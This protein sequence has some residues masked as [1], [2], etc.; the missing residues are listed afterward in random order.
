M[1]DRE[2][3]LENF[4]LGIN[5]L[6]AVPKARCDRVVKIIEKYHKCYVLGTIEKSDEYPDA[7]VWMEGMAK[8]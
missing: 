6:L 5:M 3:F 4:S 1:I 7:K 8:W 2:C